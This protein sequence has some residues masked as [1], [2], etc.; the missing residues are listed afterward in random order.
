MNPHELKT[1]N[2][3]RNTKKTS[4]HH[5][6]VN[7]IGYREKN[8]KMSDTCGRLISYNNNFSL[9]FILHLFEVEKITIKS[10]KN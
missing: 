8:P 1:W 5:F 9:F 7:L 10:E 3:V 4:H 2:N 6:R